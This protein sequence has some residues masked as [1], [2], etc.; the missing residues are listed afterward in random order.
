MTKTNGKKIKGNKDDAKHFIDFYY[1]DF[2]GIVDDKNKK[3]TN[4]TV[5]LIVPIDDG[6]SQKKSNLAEHKVP[7]IEDFTDAEAVIKSILHLRNSVFIHKT[8][9]T[10]NDAVKKKFNTFNC[11]VLVEHLMLFS[12]E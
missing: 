9:G 11:S 7:Q 8:D 6:T 2:F 10:H 3:T 12:G 4:K 1:T 5:S